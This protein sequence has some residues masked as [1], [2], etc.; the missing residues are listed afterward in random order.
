MKPKSDEIKTSNTDLA[1][2]E[3]VQIQERIEILDVIRGFALLGVLIAN[4][5]M[6]WDFMVKLVLP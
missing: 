4:M 2:A 3:P 5:A 1:T 6:V